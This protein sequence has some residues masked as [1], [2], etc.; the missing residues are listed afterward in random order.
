MNIV[1]TGATSFIG[2]SIIQRLIRDSENR[3]WAV[4]RPNSM[5]RNNV[6]ESDNINV[7]ELDMQEIGELKQFV[8][9]P[10][11]VFVHLAWEGVRVPYR[12]DAD[13]QNGNYIAALKAMETCKELNCTKFIASGSQAEYGYMQGIISEDY[14][15]MPNTEYG[16]A[17]Y[18]AYCTL[19]EYA[20]KN[21]IDFIWGRIFSVYGPGDYKGSLIMTCIDKMKRGEDIPLTECKQEWD[22]LY[23]DEL[24]EIFA[25]FVER[26]CESGVYN[27]AS[28]NHRMLKQYVESIKE[29]LKSKSRLEY[30]KIPYPKS[31]MVS[32][33]PDIE[34][35]QNE[36]KWNSQIT[37]E[38]GVRYI[39][40]G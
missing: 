18:H 27:I 15:C 21:Q 24:A 9:E 30:G 20:K 3:I 6:P 31:G 14:P 5:N 7:V 16:K 39:L 37:F 34:K 38:D 12:D 40:Q 2:A 17:K 8:R 1:I 22:Y 29:I 28:G 11:D 25:R 26:K 23:I 33:I 4:I 32:F 13:I 19:L 10:V 35:M 36:L